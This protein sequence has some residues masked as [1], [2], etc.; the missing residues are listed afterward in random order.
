MEYVIQLAHNSNMKH[1]NRYDSDKL[2]ERYFQTAQ[3]DPEVP[4]LII[5][6]IKDVKYNE[7]FD[8]AVMAQSPNYTPANADFII[9][10]FSEY[11]YEI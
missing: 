6:T 1:P 8:F 7:D 10:I 11:I 4:M 3:K 9:D 5:P 2:K